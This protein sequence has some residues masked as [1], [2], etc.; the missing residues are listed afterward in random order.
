MKTQLETPFVHFLLQNGL[1]IATYKKGVMINLSI[2]RQVVES[3][4]EFTSSREMPVLILSEGQVRMDKE[5]RDFLA[6][7]KG[8]EGL[9]AAA[10]VLRNPFDWAL[11]TFFLHLRRPAMPTKLFVSYEAAIKWLC[12]FVH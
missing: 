12:I 8:T 5:A 2:A 7:E 1:L 4:L 3:R 10:M 9:V 6:S 11:G